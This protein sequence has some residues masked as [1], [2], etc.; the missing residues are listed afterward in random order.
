MEYKNIKEY[1]IKHNKFIKKVEN[2]KIFLLEH[3]YKHM[4]ITKSLV[5]MWRTNKEYKE[6]AKRELYKQFLILIDNLKEDLKARL[7]ML[8]I[9]EPKQARLI[10]FILQALD[11]TYN[12]NLQTAKIHNNNLLTSGINNSNIQIN[13]YNKSTNKPM[14]TDELSNDKQL[15]R[16]IK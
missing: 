10:C 13:M 15:D 1:T 12:A 6:S 2:D 14:L 11:H 8:A 7:I 3:Y 4:N 5:S 9:E 16:L